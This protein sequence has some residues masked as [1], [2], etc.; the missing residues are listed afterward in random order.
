MPNAD[1]DGRLLIQM[2]HEF[3]ATRPHTKAFTSLGQLRYFSCIQH[4][5]GVVGNS[6][7]GLAEIPS[8]KKGTVNIGDRQKGRLKASSVLD[9][10]LIHSSISQAINTLFKEEFKAVLYGL[11]TPC[12]DYSASDSI[13]SCL[14]TIESKI[15]SLKF[16]YTLR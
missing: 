5:D 1:T 15:S 6:S 7:S 2:I 3:C 8:F 4:V 13:V 11:V 16:F 12:A 10:N 9:C 14:C